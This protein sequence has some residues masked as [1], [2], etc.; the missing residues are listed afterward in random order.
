[1]VE[2]RQINLNAEI[3]ALLVSFGEPWS[4]WAVV[5]KTVT[6]DDANYWWSEV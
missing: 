2:T 4:Y 5:N 1:M 6:P 3:Y